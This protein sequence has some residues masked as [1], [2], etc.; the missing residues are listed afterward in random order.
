MKSKQ[1]TVK[2]SAVLLSVL[3]LFGSLVPAVFAAVDE[4]NLPEGYHMTADS[5]Y[6]VLS[7]LTE[8]QF[9]INNEDNSS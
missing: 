8:R 5:V 4:A 9:T 3:M 6:H 7:G 1:T 2:L